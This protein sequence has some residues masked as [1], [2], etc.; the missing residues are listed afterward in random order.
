MSFLKKKTSSII[1]GVIM[2]VLMVVLLL[3][4]L[5]NN[6]QYD[7]TQQQKQ[8]QQQKQKQNQMRSEIGFGE[9][10]L[11]QYD[12]ESVVG[13]LIIDDEGSVN[14]DVDEDLD[15][16]M[17][18]RREDMCYEEKVCEADDYKDDVEGLPSDQTQSS[19]DPAQQKVGTATQDAGAD[20]KDDDDNTSTESE[21]RRIPRRK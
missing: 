9:S 13:K 19:P 3:E 18:D 15:E 10:K 16:N 21:Y 6:T 17:K 1:F 4:L 11:E 12:I 7:K 14:A 8:Q 2:C 5:Q 20:D